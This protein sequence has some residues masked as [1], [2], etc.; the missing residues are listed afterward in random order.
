MDDAT[1]NQLRLIV[2]VLIAFLPSILLYRYAND[3]LRMHEMRAHEA[4]LLQLAR[5]TAVEYEQ[6][7]VESRQLLGALAE[8]PEI[9]EGRGQ[10]C[11]QRLAS[12]LNHTPQ[13]TTL[14]LIGV[15]GYLAC[16]SLTVDGGLY[17]G[18]R[19][20]YALATTTRQFSVGNYALGRI[21]GKPTVGVA[22]PIPNPE[23]SDASNVLAASIDLSALGERARERNLPEGTT[24]TM[25]D[26]G[27]NVL[28][29]LPAGRHPLGYDT[30]GAVA[31]ETFLSAPLGLKEP[32]IETGTDLDGV[33]RLFAVA[34]FLGGNDRMAGFLV[35]GREEATLLANVD[36]V[37]RAEFRFLALTGIAVIILAWLFGHYALVRVVRVRSKE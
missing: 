4:E 29:R 30:V 9:R 3:T 12:V 24:F 8:F 28:V 31:P 32:F 36:A 27:S 13:Y 25:L 2:L 26:R 22:Y 5:V 11:N 7:V 6:L 1:R 37:V 17:L 14:S 33:D 16:G 19:T 23:G 15:D 34:P 20:Y 10:A 18:D 35:I 21:T